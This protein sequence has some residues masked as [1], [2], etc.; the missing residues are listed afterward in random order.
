MKELFGVQADRGNPGRLLELQRRLQRRGGVGAG[1]DDPVASPTAEPDGQVLPRFLAEQRR[2]QIGQPVELTRDGV[3]VTDGSRQRGQHRERGGIADGMGPRGFLLDRAERGLGPG[4]AG[5]ALAGDGDRAAAAGR[6]ARD[7][8]R[9]VAIGPAMG[10]RDHRRPA[11]EIGP[12]VHELEAVDGA[13]PWPQAADAREQQLADEGRVPGGADAGQ[14]DVRGFGEPRGGGR[15]RA[16]LA[17][18]QQPEG[19]GLRVDRVVHVVGMTG[20]QRLS[21]AQDVLD[22]TLDGG[23]EEC[24]P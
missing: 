1:A 4:G 16:V 3:V 20:P 21:R 19:T 22:H 24:Q 23:P 7:R 8:L 11:A 2:E 14:P 5:A 18:R 15:Q 17:A 13:R 10:H 9:D 12:R 6:R